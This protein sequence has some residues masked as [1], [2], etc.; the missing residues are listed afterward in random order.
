MDAYEVGGQT[1]FN[2]LYRWDDKRTP[3]LSRHGLTAAEYQAF[4]TEQ[5][6]KGFRLSN[7]TSYVEA[8]R[9]RYACIFEKKAGPAWIAYHGRT[10]A[11]QLAEVARLD[12]DGFGPVN[13]SVVSING[14]RSYAAFFEK[15]DGTSWRLHTALTPAQYEAKWE[16]EW[17]AGR[18][19]TYLSAYQHDG[20]VRFSAVFRTSRASPAGRHDLLVAQ[21]GAL[22]DEHVRAGR[23]TRC[24]AGYAVGG[25]ARFGAVWR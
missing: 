12:K 8:G 9:V 24:V 4:F 25:E 17:K 19:A 1:F 21:L 23:L 14:E 3:W 20:G 2:A 7:L 5:T 11:Q 22:I 16:E 10:H 15:D 6:G 13:V 18:R